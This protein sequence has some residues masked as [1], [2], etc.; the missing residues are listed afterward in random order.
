VSAALLETRRRAV[1]AA[2][3]ADALAARIARM[4]KELTVVRS[5]LA[6]VESMLLEATWQAPAV[7]PDEAAESLEAPIDPYESEESTESE[8]RVAVPRLDLDKGG[9]SRAAA[10]ALFGH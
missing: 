8:E 5:R 2:L 10:Q 4:S 6:A 9:L 3:R 7:A 1:A